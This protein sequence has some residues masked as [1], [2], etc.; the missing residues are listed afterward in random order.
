MFQSLRLQDS[1][2]LVTGAE[3]ELV[4]QRRWRLSVMVQKSWSPDDGSLNCW[5]LSI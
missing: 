4:G 2:A 3:V 1:V 5:R